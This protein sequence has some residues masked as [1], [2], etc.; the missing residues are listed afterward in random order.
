LS[1]LYAA[2]SAI[3]VISRAILNDAHLIST[4]RILQQWREEEE[5]NDYVEGMKTE[6]G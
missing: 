4:S 6:T 3:I 2:R 5:D 1:E